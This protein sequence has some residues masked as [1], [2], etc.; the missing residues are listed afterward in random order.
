LDWIAVY[1]WS[2]PLSGNLNLTDRMLRAIDRSRNQWSFDSS[3]SDCVPP[4][5]ALFNSNPRSVAFLSAGVLCRA[6][7]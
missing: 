1:A 4:A 3:T 2:T 5:A 6:F 7:L